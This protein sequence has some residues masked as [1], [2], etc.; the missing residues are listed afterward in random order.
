M[1]QVEGK[2]GSFSCFYLFENLD[3]NRDYILQTAKDDEGD[4]FNLPQAL[5]EALRHHCG[6]LSCSC[7]AVIEVGVIACSLAAQ[8]CFCYL[9]LF[10][11]SSEFLFLFQILYNI[12]IP[13]FLFFTVYA[14]SSFSL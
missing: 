6:K 4:M 1:S 10:F 12:I 2:H 13:I 5:P 7:I 11:A 14:V 9:N 8:T 3:D